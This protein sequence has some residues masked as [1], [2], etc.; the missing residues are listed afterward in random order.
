MELNKQFFSSEEHDKDP[1]FVTDP[2]SCTMQ[3]DRIQSITFGGRNSWF[4]MLR[5]HFNSQTEEQMKIAPFLS[6]ECI[7]IDIGNRDV[8]LV[9]K[10]EEDMRNVLKFMI[11]A[12]RTLDGRRGTAEKMLQVMNQQG[13]DEYRQTNETIFVPEAARREI[14]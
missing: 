13:C 1:D 10:S 2:S 8:D 3:I 6:W 9:I 7:S 14:I 4:W 12:M 5:K 11:Q